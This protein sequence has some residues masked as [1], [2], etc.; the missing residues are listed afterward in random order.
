MNVL[1]NYSSTLILVLITPF[2][3]Y[4]SIMRIIKSVDVQ[5]NQA[6][7]VAVTGL[8]INGVSMLI[9]G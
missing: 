7:P 2:V 4:K 5:Y 3:E 6:F 1:G 9:L 8:D